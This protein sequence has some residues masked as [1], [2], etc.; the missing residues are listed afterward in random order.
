MP[1]KY[2]DAEAFKQDLIARGFCPPIV[3]NALENAPAADVIEIAPDKLP[4]AIDEHKRLV[5]AV[6]ACAVDILRGWMILGRAASVLVEDEL[7]FLDCRYRYGMTWDETAE[8]MNY[9]RRSIGRIRQQI[10]E[11]ISQI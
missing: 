10:L 8:K 7:S 5:D 4:A 9:S 6:N 11:K 3:K 2:I 1:K